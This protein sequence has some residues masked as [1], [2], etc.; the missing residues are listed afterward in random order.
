[1]KGRID[2]ELI[3]KSFNDNLSESEQEELNEWLQS[4]EKHLA[5]FNNMKKVKSGTSWKSYSASQKKATWGKLNLTKK[6]NK[7]LYRRL[8]AIAS[9]AVVLFGIVIWQMLPKP[10]EPVLA[11]NISFDPGVKKAT[12]VLNSGKKLELTAK[13]DTVIK[14]K[15]V[16]IKNNNSQLNYHATP[17]KVKKTKFNKL[18]VPRG[19]EYYLTLSDGTNVW[20]NSETI[21]RYPVVFEKKRRRVEVIGEAYFEVK[22]DS[23]RPFIV[24]S[25]EHSVVVYGTSFNVKSYP[26][27]DQIETTL[28][29]GKVKVK[30]NFLEQR[31]TFL[32]PG[33]QSVFS[34][35]TGSLKK[36][37]VN[38]KPYTSWKDGRFYFRNMTLEEIMGT[39]E[40][41]YDVKFVFKN[42]KDKL[43][44]FNGNLKRYDNI[45]TILNQLM[46]TNEITFTAYENIIHVN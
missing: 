42:E 18:M 43:L 40:R 11:Q 8:T 3:W 19:A 39:L 23:L 32:T 31:E 34:K 29:E 25:G 37:K 9:V 5:F 6:N 45:Q 36:Q 10:V 38:T 4:D 24:M 15:N 13:K 27:E 35:K 28:V 2:Y 17:K 12:L 22:T 46:K 7:T 41:W 30:A 44:R 33:H 26:N 21:I 16:L 14:R 20:V 1:M